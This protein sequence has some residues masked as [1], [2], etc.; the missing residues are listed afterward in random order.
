MS[1][2]YIHPH[3]NVFVLFQTVSHQSDGVYG[4][5]VVNQ[6]QPLEPHATL[7]DYDRS[8]ENTLLF[9]VKFPRLLTGNLED[10]ARVQPTELTINGD[11]ENFK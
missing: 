9:A 10:T 7:Y 11:D 8:T 2:T 4:S 5:L 3:C 1:V 6:P